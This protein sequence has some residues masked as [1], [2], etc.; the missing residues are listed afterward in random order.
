MA[1]E[2]RRRT[3]PGNVDVVNADVSDLAGVPMR[4]EVL[5]H[6]QTGQDI[7]AENTFKS[8]GGGLR[9]IGEITVGGR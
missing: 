1:D 2:R 4:K 7:D 8:Q 9:S 3:G 6:V 5:A